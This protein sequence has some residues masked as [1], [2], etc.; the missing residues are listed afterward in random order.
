MR[1]GAK[2]HQIH[3]DHQIPSNTHVYPICFIKALVTET[4]CISHFFHGKNHQKFVASE[5]HFTQQ[6]HG[7]KNVIVARG[8]I[9]RG[10]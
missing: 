9:S 1:F 5:E 2:F 3:S 6:Q 7:L 10:A 8:C 4:Q